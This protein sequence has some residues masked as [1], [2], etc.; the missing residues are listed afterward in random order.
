MAGKDA[1]EAIRNF[2]EPLQEALSCLIH[3]GMYVRSMGDP[4]SALYALMLANSPAQLGH[5]R[6]LALEMIQHF[7]VIEAPVPRG[8]YKVQTVAYYYTVREV[9]DPGRE[10]FAYH[11]HPRGHSHITFPHLHLYHGAGTIRD[12]VRKAHFPTGRMALED[13]L[14]LVIQAFHVIPLR[15]DWEGILDRTQA[16]FE[17]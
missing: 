15:D 8:P 9:A 5:D 12:E 2:E 3:P 17:G 14:R 11:W 1:R 10:V 7:R 13:I 6:R 4:S 16:A